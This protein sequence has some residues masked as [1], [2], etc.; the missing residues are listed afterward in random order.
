MVVVESVVDESD[1]DALSVDACVPCLREVHRV[2]WDER[3]DDMPLLV[4][5]RVV[6]VQRCSTLAAKQDQTAVS[7]WDEKGARCPQR[8]VAVCRGGQRAM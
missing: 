6:D 3:V 7:D 5:Q 8:A 4:Q 1:V 2:V